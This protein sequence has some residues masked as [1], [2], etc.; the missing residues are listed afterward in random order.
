MYS[1]YR[2]RKVKIRGTVIIRDATTT[3]YA[4][5]GLLPAAV[6][7]SIGSVASA[8]SVLPERPFHN[9]MVVQGGGNRAA[10]DFD[11][12][13]P[14]HQLEGVTYNQYNDEKDYS[15]AVGAS[16]SLMPTF[17]VANSSTVTTIAV[18]WRL[19]IVYETE[20]YERTI[21]SQS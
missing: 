18:D 17:Q 21:L 14:L 9:F 7:T 5:F 19:S 2:V 11:I 15:A 13:L 1:R 10:V 3:A 20:F 16:P 4:F 8:Y 6:S 12:D